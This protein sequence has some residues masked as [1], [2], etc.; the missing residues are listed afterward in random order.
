M[1]PKKVTPASWKPEYSEAILN[2]FRN[3][4]WDP[5]ETDGKR[6]NEIL[7]SHP[8]TFAVL[9]PF[10]S[11]KQGG[12]K[13]NN[14]QLYTYYKNIGSEY[15]TELAQA[16]IRRS[17]RK[18]GACHFFPCTGAFNFPIYLHFRYCLLSLESFLQNQEASG[19]RKRAFGNKK[20]DVD[21]LEDSDTTFYSDND[22]GGGDEYDNY[23]DD[24]IKGEA[25]DDNKKMASSKPKAS[26]PSVGKSFSATAGA[27]ASNSATK[28]SDD[29][30]FI[31]NRMKQMR[32]SKQEGSGW[33]FTCV[34]PH[35]WWTYTHNGVKYVRCEFLCWTSHEK[36]CVPK[37]SKC[38]NFLYFTQKIPERF[39]DMAHQ[40]YYYT[41]D[42]LDGNV[43]SCADAI[44]Q[45]GVNVENNIR[46]AFEQESITPVVKVKLPFSVQQDFEDPYRPGLPGYELCSYPHESDERRTFFVFSVSVKDSTVPRKK[47]NPGFT[48]RTWD[49]RP[50]GGGAGGGDDDHDM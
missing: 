3:L 12:T 17:D 1:P 44:I 7:K 47:A 41:H 18:F 46:E 16:G 49:H 4:N 30:E 27:P 33:N 28:E 31:A 29:V 40:F 45:Q 8:D 42:Q 32:F 50:A 9:Q 23:F 21:D 37:I 38:G 11:V 10:F 36:E 13:A 5:E 22:D 25:K 35:Y 14:N 15:I 6:L 43:Q 26:I 19:G 39:L 20:E 48:A 34:H 2:G 24:D